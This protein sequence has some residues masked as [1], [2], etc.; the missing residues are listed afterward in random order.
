[1]KCQR[2]VPG[3][4]PA[5]RHNSCGRFSARSVT[6]SPAG[7]RQSR[8]HRLGHRHERHVRT[9]P[10]GTSEAARGGPQLQ[11]GGRRESPSPTRRTRS[12]PSGQ[13]RA[14]ASIPF[15]PRCRKREEFLLPAR[16]SPARRREKTACTIDC[17]HKKTHDKAHRDSRSGSLCECG[18]VRL[19]RRPPCKGVS[20]TAP[21]VQRISV[22]PES[23]AIIRMYMDAN[24]HAA[25]TGGTVEISPER[26]GVSPFRRGHNRRDAGGD[27][28]SDDRSAMESE[29]LAA[30]RS[31]F[32]FDSRLRP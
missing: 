5:F 20:M 26:G 15:A 21:I 7:S 12:A 10:A 4:D 13:A 8:R 3:D 9:L 27:T 17:V 11:R 29:P 1:M 6:P 23:G 18:R 30:G 24:E 28:R 25:F 22:R 16:P 2:T 19:I 32:N 31:R 14:V